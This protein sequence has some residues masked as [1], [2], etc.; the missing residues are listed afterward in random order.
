MQ[1]PERELSAA[2]DYVERDIPIANLKLDELNFRTDEVDGQRAAIKAMIQEQGLGLV[3]LAE[4]LL[5]HGLMPGERL[6][7]IPDESGEAESFVVM[8]GN[9]RTTVMKILEQPDLAAET[10]IY[11]RI[12]ELA[13]QFAGRPLRTLPCVVLPQRQM[14]LVWVEVKHST[15][16]GGAGVEKWSAPATARFSEYLR[17]RVSRW[18]ATL[19]FLREQGIDV[20]Q[21]ADGI[22]PKTTAVSRVLNAGAI[23]KE[24]GVIYSH[25][26]NIEF[27]NGDLNAGATLLTSLMEAMASPNFSTNDVHSTENRVAYI[28]RFS[29]LSVKIRPANADG[30]AGAGAST[31]GNSQE[32]FESES[33]GID[34]GTGS[35]PEG[36]N[37]GGDPAEEAR[38]ETGAATGP[39]G[40]NEANSSAFPD[41]GEPGAGSNPSEGSGPEEA[42]SA[43]SASPEEDTDHR[44]T[45]SETPDQAAGDPAGEQSRGEAPVDQGGG[46]P[47]V[48][49]NE[50]GSETA[51]G[52]RRDGSAG[53]H[54][55]PRQRTT[56]ASTR[57]GEELKIADPRINQLYHEVRKLKVEQHT[58][59][60]AVLIRVFLELSCEYYLSREDVPVPDQIIR[61]NQNRPTNWH[62]FGVRFR[63]K[64]EA[65]INHAGSTGDAQRF[66]EIRRGL[67]SQDHLHSPENLHDYVHGLKTI[68]SAR[69]LIII[70]DR[71]HPLFA[72]MFS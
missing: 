26:G 59:V 70:W 18:R 3:K 45:Q 58:A 29:A 27:E 65:A 44:S 60:A 62:T 55:H 47:S 16:M 17:G 52:E 2:L 28:R 35:Q 37:V 66:T 38:P 40:A 69:D 25:D 4:H 21:I 24:L 46:E 48:G 56:L 57:R 31:D 43:A 71:Y 30:E 14:A 19:R 13:R 64:I 51:S 50:D 7:V 23:K 49:G 5:T 34:D 10:S 15:G 68:P 39:N 53:L 1:E 9:R 63:E 72:H 41:D 42:A 33:S 8:E 61:R 12:V 11:G 67:G 20:A 32:F 54:R 36:S 22:R 6:L